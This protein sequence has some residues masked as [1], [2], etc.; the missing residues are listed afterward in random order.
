MEKETLKILIKDRKGKK[1]IRKS[2]V[3]KSIENNDKNDF[4]CIK[5]KICP[6]G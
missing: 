1:R 4:K 3:K 2:K 6:N 5:I